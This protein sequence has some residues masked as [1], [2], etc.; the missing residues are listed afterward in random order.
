MGGEGLQVR[1]QGF[2]SGH[3]GGEACWTG[4]CQASSWRMRLEQGE[5]SRLETRRGVVPMQTYLQQLEV[6]REGGRLKTGRAEKAPQPPRSGLLLCLELHDRGTGRGPGDRKTF[7]RAAWA[8]SV[9]PSRL[10]RPCSP[11]PHPASLRWL[12]AHTPACLS[13]PPSL[14]PHPQ[15]AA[16]SHIPLPARHPKHP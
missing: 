12:W 6:T 3:F 1:N 16:H 11:R 2:R 7:L 8:R 9:S 14:S 4:R 15:P 13:L 10:S 5:G